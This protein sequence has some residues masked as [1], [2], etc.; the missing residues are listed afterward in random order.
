MEILRTREMP[1]A[2]R[3][4]AAQ[5]QRVLIRAKA[6]HIHPIRFPRAQVADLNPF[7]VLN[8]PEFD[9]QLDEWN[10]R[11]GVVIYDRDYHK[12]ENVAP[13]HAQLIAEM[14]LSPE[15]LRVFT[16]GT[17]EICAIFMPP[18]WD[19]HRRRAHYVAPSVDRCRQFYDIIRSA[20]KETSIAQALRIR[21]EFTCC[22]DEWM[23][24]QLGIDFPG[25][26]WNLRRAM[27]LGRQWKLV[28]RVIP[29]CEPSDRTLLTP[30][31]WIIERCPDIDGVYLIE[32][33]SMIEVAR[34]WKV[35]LKRLARD[36]AIAKLDTL[37]CYMLG[38][39]PPP[40]AQIEHAHRTAHD[41]LAEM[42]KLMERA[43]D[44]PLPR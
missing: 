37:F 26:I 3:A 35:T 2:A 4:L 16:L 40:W 25:E 30:Y 9:R 38:E 29:R 8:P 19:E 33:S 24:A 12:K 32:G 21:E 27:L 10:L 39:L 7:I 22:S 11:G 36:G 34:H 28:S 1:R 17:R 31:R 43:A 41:G 18:N 15:R 13:H 42:I 23:C 5:Y 6:T 44:L 20:P 14:P